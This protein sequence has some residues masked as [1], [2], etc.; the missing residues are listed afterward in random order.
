MKLLNR[1]T[2]AQF[3][4]LNVID[5]DMGNLRKKVNT[6]CIV[7]GVEQSAVR[8]R[9]YLPSGWFALAA[10]VTGWNGSSTK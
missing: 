1:L 8:C 3:Q 5:P 4:E 2:V 10:S 6:V 7:D 9:C